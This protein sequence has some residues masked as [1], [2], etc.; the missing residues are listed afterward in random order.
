[1]NTTTMLLSLFG[2]TFSLGVLLADSPG[3]TGKP[4]DVQYLHAFAETRGFMLGRP[5]RPKP[6]PD[7]QF[8][9]FLRSQPRAARMSLFEFDVAAGKTREL[10]T[11][12]AL[13]KGAEE[14]LSP[15]EKA[16]RERQ[17]V[18]VG[19][20]ADFQLSEDGRLILLSVSGK[21][22]V[23]DRS[24]GKATELATGAGTILD[25]RFSPPG[26]RVTY[27]RDYDVYAFDLKT[28]KEER[29]TTGGTEQVTHG[30]A[31][32]VAQEEM[33]RP[34]GYWLSPDGKS[35]AFEEADATGVEV[36]N[37]ADPAHPDRPPQP[38]FYP[39][40]GKNNV[41]VRLGIQS[42]DGLVWVKW[43]SEK[44]PYLAQVRW[45]KQGPLTL[46]VQT[47][48][49][50]ELALLRVDPKTGK[51]TTLLTEKDPAWINLHQEMPRW[52]DGDLGFLWV[53][54]AN[55]GPSLELRNIDGERKRVLLPARAGYQ[56]LADVEDKAGEVFFIG[57]DNPTEARLYRVSLNGGEPMLL[58]REPG[59]Y[60]AAFARNHSIYAL[61][62]TSQD[63]MPK[64]TV[65]K[66]DGKLIGTLPSIAESPS[67][68]PN[69][70]IVKVGEGEGYYASIVRPRDFDNKMRYPVI[71]HV[72]GGPT[73]SQVT[74][75]MAG[76]LLDQWLADQG[77]IV[78]S[79]DGR[80][81]PNR[82]RDWE[83][84]IHKK[85][86]SLPLEGQVAGL[87]ALGKRFKEM[88]LDRVGIYGWSFGGYA[89]ALAVL[90]RP[91]VFKAAI[92]GAPV[93]DWLDYDTHYTE[94]YLGVPEKPDDPAYKEGSLLTYAA[95]LK[96]PL[97]LIHGT[98]DDNVYFRH[99]LKLADA[100]F[101]AG[102]DFEL[103]PLSGLTHMVPDPVVTLR[104]WTKTAAFF[105]RELGKPTN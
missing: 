53:S 67:I 80:G 102:K 85:F 6:T 97:L 103:L 40:P 35:V 47:R 52:L 8:V 88:D 24:T 14:H 51:T 62:A 96:R 76:F 32:F 92:A 70:E 87:K 105:R 20:F 55:G 71:V 69:V 86:G 49:Q 74:C 43:D 26:D 99:T 5:A 36:W 29:L 59:E 58:T 45:H 64:T 82:G 56:G 95:D 23:V 101:R 79:I 100:L 83:R 30:L 31:E 22:Y 41:K 78:V 72:Y 57:S 37:V 93:T 81:T 4:L 7:G 25:P 39:R 104:L 21:L 12:E 15:E 17:R 34:T 2:L 3:R 19:G 65:H 89:S 75:A 18:S 46:Q 73:F 60:A 16:R 48:D 50:K 13:L 77:F 84:A 42:P 11:P 1:M 66:E 68:L 54:E 33:D 10:L 94:R 9:L 63:S 91:D 28:H 98:A 61:T 44:Y 27:V 90:R 38:S